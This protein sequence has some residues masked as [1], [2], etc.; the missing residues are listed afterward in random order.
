M[1][2]REQAGRQLSSR[3]SGHQFDAD[4]RI[5]CEV[6]HRL[7]ECEVLAGG[8]SHLVRDHSQRQPGLADQVSSAEP[9]CSEP[10]PEGGWDLDA[11]SRLLGQ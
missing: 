9:Q 6:V 4:R 3:Q 5:S 1:V 2:G 11:I 8:D 10:G 7:P